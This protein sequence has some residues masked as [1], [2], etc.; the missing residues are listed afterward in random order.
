V[1]R[2]ERLERGVR[3][4]RIVPL[5]MDAFG[6]EPFPSALPKPLQIAA[7]APEGE[8]RG[9]GE[10]D[11]VVVGCLAKKVVEPVHEGILGQRGYEGD[12]DT[13]VIPPGTQYCATRCKAGKRNPSK[14]ATFAT[15]CKSLQ[16]L[17]DHS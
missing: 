11:A 1:R 13:T 17:T 10:H 14:H 4:L 2:R 3:I 12:V 6:E 15:P 16:P 7:D 5:Y 9:C 8:A